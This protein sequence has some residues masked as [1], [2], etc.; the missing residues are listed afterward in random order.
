M[1]FSRREVFK[2][3]GLA[4]LVGAVGFPKLPM[5]KEDTLKYRLGKTPAR[6]AV[7]LKLRDYVD[8]SKLPTPPP[9]F[10]HE[11]LVHDWQVLG[12][13]TVGDCAIAGP[14]HAEML[15]NAESGKTIS[16]NTACTL[17]AYSAITKY[18]PKQT[19]P[20]SGENPTDNGSDVAEVAEYWRTKGLKD[21]DGKV[22]KIDTYLALEPGNVEELFVAMYLFNGAGI[23]VDFPQEWMEAF[24]HGQ[25]WDTLAD[26]TPMGGHY[27]WGVGR[28][29]GDINAITWGK[30]QLVTPAAYEEFNDEAFV[31]LT[32]ENLVNGRDLEGFDLATLR[33]DLKALKGQPHSRPVEKVK[34]VADETSGDNSA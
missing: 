19:D 12:N 18:D 34:K 1:D 4:G 32:E 28:R 3:L 24:G 9:D 29:G 22:H 25:I 2:L 7:K 23:G 6:H 17:K 15:W 30:T 14:F 33:A 16:V 27:I 20:I 26:P 13:D 5:L 11:T 8:L 21:A 31:Y 10:G